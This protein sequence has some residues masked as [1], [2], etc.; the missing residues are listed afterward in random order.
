MVTHT[1]WRASR[2]R[3]LLASFAAAIGIALVSS[4]GVTGSGPAQ[5]GGEAEQKATAVYEKYAT[6]TGDERERQLYEEA[7]STAGGQITVYTSNSSINDIVAGFQAKY[8]G[9]TVNAN[10]SEPAAFIQRF[11]QEQEAGHYGVDVIEDADASLITQRGLAGK[12]ANDPVTSQIRNLDAVQGNFTPTRGGAVVVS[13]NKS[14]VNESDLPRSLEGFT[15]PKWKGRLSITDAE[16]AWYM[17]LSKKWLAEGKSQEDIDKIFE[18]LSSYSTIVNSHTL[19]AEL[20]AA[21]ESDVALTTFNHAVDQLVDEGAP[22][23]WRLADGQPLVEPVIYGPEGA[24]PI[25]NAPNPAGALL[26][27]D[28][29]LGEGQAIIAKGHRPTAIPQGGSD[30]LAGVELLEWPQD[31]YVNNR[32]TWESRFSEFMKLGTAARQ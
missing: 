10:R 19:Q 31:E 20:L 15:D 6:I 13:W 25:V 7:K 1:R 24:V 26:F 4:C 17:T 8:P 22:V 28:Y 9:L 23:A 16:W 27:I 21:G 11:F 29:E 2:S 5:S 3:A 32:D 30:P 14:K 18:T 12:Y